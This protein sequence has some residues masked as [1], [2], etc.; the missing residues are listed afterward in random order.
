MRFSDYLNTVNWT[1]ELKNKLQHQLVYS[2]HATTC[3]GTVRSVP[4]PEI[5]EEYI[6]KNV[7]ARDGD[8]S[9]ANSVKTFS[10]SA[11]FILFVTMVMVNNI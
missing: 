2:P 9:S 7:C 4:Y 8:D 10:F 11:F 5:K 3:T 1:D 6:E